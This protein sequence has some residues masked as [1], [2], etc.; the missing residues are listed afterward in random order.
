MRVRQREPDFFDHWIHPRSSSFIHLRSGWGER[1]V[2]KE[3]RMITVI[4]PALN[5]SATIA[6]VVELARRDPRVTDVIVVDDGSIDGTPE[7]AAAAGAR[8][9][10]S[11]MLGK[12][13][14]MEDGMRAARNE[15][16]VYLDGDLTSLCRDLVDRLTAPLFAET[17]DFV[18]AS[19]SRTAGRVT[20]LTAKP[21]LRTFFPELAH[22]EQ[23]LGGI[24][25]ARRGLLRRLRFESDYGVDVGLLIDAAAAGVRI[26]EVDVGHI[27]HDSHPLEVLGDMATQVVRALLERAARYG[28]LTPRQIDEVYEIERHAEAELAVAARKVDKVAQLALFAMDHVLVCGDSWL[29]LAPRGRCSSDLRRL[30]GDE[31]LP[32]EDRMRRIASWFAGVSRK[33]LEDTARRLPL[34]P[35]ACRVV[36]ALRKA[37][38]RVG[39]VTHGFHVVSELVRR[40]V[41]ADFSLAH[42]IR[43]K[44]GRATGQVVLS[45]A[46]LVAGGCPRHTCC[47]ANAIEYLLARTGIE[48]DRVLAVGTDADDLCM[49]KAAGRSVAFRA[50][51]KAAQGAAHHAVEGSLSDI[52]T[53]VS[54]G[55]FSATQIPE[56]ATPAG[57]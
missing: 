25:A 51:S 10:T 24:I 26:A 20:I 35:D 39:V 57:R 17:A 19:F 14:S 44:A 54:A 38:F 3:V 22:F 28:R 40:R 55:P 32:V 45:P 6:S 43:F 31:A 56:E 23:P 34:A 7:L 33:S 50:H 30:V 1:I 18:K 36:V 13:V 48:R 5:E 9:I 41:F 2:V 49:L 11:T 53:L 12:G 46:M 52:L 27:R 29:E 4:I 15:I 16:L 37:G 42:R 8:I 47:K 21:L